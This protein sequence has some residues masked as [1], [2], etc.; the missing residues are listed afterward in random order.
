[1]DWHDSSAALEVGEDIWRQQEQEL[2]HRHYEELT[3]MGTM[4]AGDGG[5]F[6]NPTAR[7]QAA[8]CT[9]LI[10]LGT[11]PGSPKFP[12]PKRKVRVAWEVE[13]RMEDGRPFL[14]FGNY[15]LS[16]NEKALF[17]KLLEG[18][19]GR[20]YRDGEEMNPRGI[21]GRNCLLNLKQNGDYVNVDSAMPLPQ[22]MPILNAVGPLLYFDIDAWDDAVFEQLSEKTQKQILQSPEARELGRG[23]PQSTQ[24]AQR[25]HT[26]PQTAPKTYVAQGEE[27]P[28]PDYEPVSAGDDFDDDIPF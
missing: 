18:W 4:K 14:V 19:R 26:P 16:A 27:P 25:A 5:T 9:Q 8:V 15:T 3:M 11:Q 24:P 1:M 7:P 23:G 6:Q 22:G 17:R 28:P 10:D 13:E 21:V 20:A 12:N 2:E